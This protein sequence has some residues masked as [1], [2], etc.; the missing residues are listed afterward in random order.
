M[1]PNS[2]DYDYS[3]RYGTPQVEETPPEPEAP[4]PV[5][6]QDMSGDS[7]EKG[8]AE[9]RAL[10]IGDQP[11][12]SSVQ[13]R[14]SP[15]RDVTMWHQAGQP[16]PAGTQPMS[17]GQA[18]MSAAANLIPSTL[19]V[20]KAALTAITNPGETLGAMRDLV[21]GVYSKVKGEMGFQHDA[22]DEKLVDA[23]VD[24]YK[25]VY[26]SE[27]GFKKALA[28][29]PAGILMDAST[30]LGGAGAIG[31]LGGIQKAAALTKLAGKIDPLGRL[32]KAATTVAGAPVAMLRGT[33]ATASGMPAYLQK[34]ATKAGAASEPM[35]NVYNRFASGEADATEY[36][37]TAQRAV[38]AD[39]A[40]AVAEYL[41]SKQGLLPG[42]P[43]FQKIDNA[44][45]KAREHTQFHGPDNAA[46]KP[47]ND[48]LDE[49][50]EIIN[51][52]KKNPHDIHAFDNLKQAL[53]DL[54][55]QT[56]NSVANRHLGALRT[57]VKDAIRDVDPA[58]D[59]IMEKYATAQNGIN[60]A[61]NM[62]GAGDKA[63]ASASLAKALRSVKDST[64][65]NMIERMAQHEPALPYMLAG[66]AANS[67]YA[68]VMRGIQ[69]MIGS[70]MLGY[71]V[72]PVAGMASMA[73]GSPKLVGKLNYG[74]G[75]LGSLTGIAPASRA[76]GSVLN[77]I[78][79]KGEI[80][81]YGGRARQ[82]NALGNEQAPEAP[83]SGDT[84]D[85]MLQT[86][87]GNKQ[88]KSGQ[89]IISPKGAVGA[90]QVMPETGPEAAQYAGEPWDKDRL[91]NDPEYNKRLGR[92]YFNHLL[93]VFGDPEK[94]AAAYN[95]GPGAVS[96]AIA[97]AEREGSDYRQHLPAE[98][99]NYIRNVMSKGH[100][101]GGRIERA[102]GGRIDEINHLVNR[103]MMKH[104]QAKRMTDK[105]TETLLNAPDEHIV[106]ALKVAQD[107]I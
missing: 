95:A 25:N 5:A 11:K 100:A 93:E 13:G 3:Q 10:G 78:P 81:Y 73:A 60:N 102:D 12:P 45:V 68:G 9:L 19:G 105:T 4:A 98:T 20:G 63:A 49:A 90:A 55:A 48:A 1:N 53:D 71:A 35:R 61:R 23:M 85:R 34:M 99:Q 67:S 58:Y 69:D 87:S 72:H 44:L 64:G 56:G 97:T 18:G 15:T 66:H 54:N 104:R 33:A 27:E 57:S 51:D 82:E 14:T 94:A 30:V 36:L 91:Y 74:V 40:Q 6:H 39:K 38:K 26:G 92:A 43:S 84:F 65:I 21:K 31:K 75:R 41:K 52:Y 7:F 107:A 50:E 59:D 103:L 42:A 46:F 96:K 106:Q 83:S 80:S 77:K 101:A 62:L 47:A 86:E 17:W 22:N 79:A 37:D 29:D 70:A 89:T 16:A 88:F 24:H 8:K 32:T 76:V 2:F 28:E